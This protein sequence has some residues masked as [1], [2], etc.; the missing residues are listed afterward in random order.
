MAFFLRLN[1]QKLI[2]IGFVPALLVAMRQQLDFVFSGSPLLFIFVFLNCV[3]AILILSDK[4]LV[5]D[6]YLSVVS[7][8]REKFVYLARLPSE[9][10]SLSRR[11]KA[12]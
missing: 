4:I 6:I 2:R 5:F 9:S 12:L 7:H 10:F 11:H 1:F 3:Y 8:I